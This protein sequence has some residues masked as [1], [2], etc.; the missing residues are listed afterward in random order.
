[1]RRIK[2]TISA[3]ENKSIGID[4]LCVDFR[5]AGHNAAQLTVTHDAGHLD[6]GSAEVSLDV[7]VV[8]EGTASLC[9]CQLGGVAASIVH[10]RDFHPAFGILDDY[11]RIPEDS[12]I[13]Y[14]G[15]FGNE[16]Q[17]HCGPC[18]H[19]RS[20][21]G[22]VFESVLDRGENAGWKH[23][24]FAPNQRQHLGEARTDFGSA[25]TIHDGDELTVLN[26]GDHE[27]VFLRKASALCGS[28]AD[29]H[30]RSDGIRS[31]IAALRRTSLYS[32]EEEY[33]M[34]SSSKASSS[35]EK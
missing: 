10:R 28:F 31:A 17:R 21:V 27:A 19:T 23:D 26:V 4:L 11:R 8:I 7:A 1:M 16:D 13:H 3:D 20:Q 34:G 12:H 29:I 2:E 22:K 32:S 14:V 33:S 9:G 25:V 6:A 18:F 24:V 30:R 5:L 35:D 15:G